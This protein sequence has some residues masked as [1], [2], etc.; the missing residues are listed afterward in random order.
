MSLRALVAVAL[1]ALAPA[2][3]FAIDAAPPFEDPDDAAR[4][5]LLAAGAQAFWFEIPADEH[6]VFMERG[7]G[8]VFG[9]D[10]FRKGGIVRLEEASALAVHAN[11]ARDEVGFGGPDIAISFNPRDAS[12][13]FQLVQGLVQFGSAAGREMKPPEELGRSEREV[14][15]AAQEFQNSFHHR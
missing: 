8:R 1:L 3:A 14:I 12:G 5:F 2:A 6:P 10:D 9:D 15:F 11:S 4:P 7:G 13:T